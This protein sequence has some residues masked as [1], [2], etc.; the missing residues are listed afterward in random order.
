[1]QVLLSGVAF[2]HERG[3]FSGRSVN[4]FYGLYYFTT[5]YLYE[6]DGTLHQGNPGELLINAPG[7]IV[8]HG[9]VSQKDSFTNDWMHISSDFGMLLQRYPIPCNTAIAIGP[10][11]LLVAA[12]R[13]VSAEQLLRQPGFR[14]KI[15]C[16]L[17]QMV[18]DLHRL[19]T[20][21]LEQTSEIRILSARDR[22]LCAP[23]HPWTLEEMAQLS[24]YSVSRFSVLYRARFGRSPKADL[25]EARL[26]MSRQQLAYSELPVSAIASACGFQS[27]YYFS[28]YFHRHTGC[29]PTEFRE[30]ARH[31]PLTN[32]RDHAIL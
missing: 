2:P 1:M 26:A 21:S 5:P 6:R 32:D 15:D 14:E 25:L 8:Y 23:E 16:I 13:Q 30:N 28:K 7:S 10:Q 17:T 29:T 18:I 20:R 24:G 12:I 22:V 31:F 9:P 27:L 19:Y 4:S 3:Y 11:N